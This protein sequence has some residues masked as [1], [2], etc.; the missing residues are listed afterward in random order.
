MSDRLIARWLR[1]WAGFCPERGCEYCQDAFDK[2]SLDL[3]H[4]RTRIA[5]ATKDSDGE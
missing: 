5:D 3:E 2:V 1:L 4:L